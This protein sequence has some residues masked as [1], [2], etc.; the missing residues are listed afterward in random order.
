MKDE[1]FQSS[2]QQQQQPK[3][4]TSQQKR[5]AEGGMNIPA[6]T[7]TV[8]VDEFMRF[9]GHLLT[10]VKISNGTSFIQAAL[11]RSPQETLHI[12]KAELLPH[13]KT[14]LLDDNASYTIRLVMDLDPTA[15]LGFFE[16]TCDDE[17]YWVHLC[18]DS[19]HTR[20]LVLYFLANFPE[21]LDFLFAIAVRHLTV[22]A[23][24]KNGCLTLQKIMSTMPADYAS[25]AAAECV[26][27]VPQICLDSH[28]HYLITYL[29]ENGDVST[30][31]EGICKVISQPA[32][33]MALARNQ[34]GSSTLEKAVRAFPVKF[35]AA[36]VTG[37]MGLE[38]S[39]LVQVAND[40]FG[41]YVVQA[42]VGVPSLD[43]SADLIKRLGG[44]SSSLTFATKIFRNVTHSTHR[45]SGDAPALP[46]RRHGNNNRN[47]NNSNNG[48]GNN[49]DGNGSN[50]GNITPPSVQSNNATKSAVETPASKSPSEPTLIFR[51]DSPPLDLMAM[52]KSVSP[53]V[54]SVQLLHSPTQQQQQQQQQPAPPLLPTPQ[55]AFTMMPPPQFMPQGMLHPHQLMHQ[56]PPQMQ[57]PYGMPPLQQHQMMPMHMAPQP[58]PGATLMAAP[59]GGFMMA[60][61]PP[62]MQ[63]QQQPQ[64]LPP[65]AMMLMTP[66]GP[67]MVM[68]MHHGMQPQAFQQ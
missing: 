61:P 7:M 44:L 38:D 60:P 46:N 39:E 34:Y 3:Q 63:Q 28:G 58:A 21:K 25:R 62:H 1:P 27:K 41:N 45:G 31:I 52:E 4:S 11:K 66:Q 65:G 9:R 14:L 13:A 57:P 10:I 16:Q 15:A 6:G 20:R 64:G 49:S 30:N 24:N 22:L 48:N 53:S 40:S 26:A 19:L 29:C 33:F 47:N 50:K 35:G 43:I 55:G 12:V 59:Q 56:M 18:C 17:D 8:T 51:T 23:C 68:P 67:V 54:L 2:Q 5:S 32:T 37:A 36:L 42:A